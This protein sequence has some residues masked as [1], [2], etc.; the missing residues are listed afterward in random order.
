MQL[1]LLAQP[2]RMMETLLIVA[3]PWLS[4]A[5]RFKGIEGRSKYGFNH[6][7]LIV[8]PAVSSNDDVY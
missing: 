5:R 4:F 6:V 3:A 2:Q 7:T 1:P 8:A